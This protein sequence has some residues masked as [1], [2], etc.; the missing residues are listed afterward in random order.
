MKKKKLDLGKKLMLNKEKIT[1]ISNPGGIAGGS[2]DKFHACNFTMQQS[3]QVCITVGGGDTCR[4]NMCGLGPSGVSC[5][6]GPGC[7]SGTP[8]CTV[9]YPCREVITDVIRC[10]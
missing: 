10:H 6:Y 7:A 1:A 3:C 9:G 4:D 2:T 5:V 8:D